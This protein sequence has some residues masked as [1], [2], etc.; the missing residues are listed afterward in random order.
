MNTLNLIK[1]NKYISENRIIKNLK[2]NYPSYEKI[3]EM[4]KDSKY[5]NIIFSDDNLRSYFSFFLGTKIS[6]FQFAFKKNNDKINFIY[7][8]KDINEKILPSRIID[9]EKAYGEKINEI[10]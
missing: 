8:V 5:Y 6:D 3:Y 2:I 10:K 1:D 7:Q 9:L 4:Y